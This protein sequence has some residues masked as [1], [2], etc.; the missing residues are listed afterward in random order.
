M[1]SN[2]KIVYS[3]YYVSIHTMNLENVSSNVIQHPQDC[4]GYGLTLSKADT[5]QTYRRLPDPP[6]FSLSPLR[7]EIY[8]L[9]CRRIYQV[10]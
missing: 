2:L 3:L 10:V 1:S 6:E 9:F 8:L 7:L 4:K 5:N